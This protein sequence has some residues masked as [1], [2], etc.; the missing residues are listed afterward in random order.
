MKQTVQPNSATESLQETAALA[1]NN[2]G[3]YVLETDVS[4]QLKADPQSYLSVLKAIGKTFSKTY[5]WKVIKSQ[6]EQDFLPSYRINI[7]TEDPVFFCF[8][9]FKKSGARWQYNSV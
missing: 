6:S 2:Q 4:E 5:A 9:D 7:R 8:G 3:Y 1:I